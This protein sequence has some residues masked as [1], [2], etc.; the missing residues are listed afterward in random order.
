MMWYSINEI[1]PN[2]FT[3]HDKKE[4][5]IY[6]VS[7]YHAFNDMR[8]KYIHKVVTIFIYEQRLRPLVFYLRMMICSILALN[9]LEDNILSQ[10]IFACKK[11]SVSFRMFPH[12]V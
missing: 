4:N 7:K 3:K 9:W 10:N 5:C 11:Q 6:F 8:A 12:G 2:D 1:Q